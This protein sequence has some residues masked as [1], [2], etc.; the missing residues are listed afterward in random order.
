MPA[1]TADASRTLVALPDHEVHAGAHAVQR[2][3]AEAH[4]AKH[5]LPLVQRPP[6]AARA[7]RQDLDRKQPCVPPR[8]ELRSIFEHSRALQVTFMGQ[9][10]ICKS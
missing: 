10:H 2:L 7:L 1:V 6:A 4:R 9:L 5:G 3:Q 8:K